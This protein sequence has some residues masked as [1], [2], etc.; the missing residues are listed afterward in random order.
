MGASDSKLS[1]KKSIFR[2]SDEARIPAHDP[3][4]TAFWELPETQ[5]DVS[6]LFSH[7]DIRRTR[8]KAFSNLESLLLA[9]TSRL[10]DLRDHPSFPDPEAAPEKHALNCIRTLT[11][12]LPFLYEIEHLDKWEKGF[13]W[14]P[15]SRLAHSG[16]ASQTEVLFDSKQGQDSPR[17]QAVDGKR[18]QRPLGEELIDTLV[19]M[20]FF[21]GFTVPPPATGQNKVTYAIWQSGV[22]CHTTLPT[23]KEFERNRCDVLKLIIVMVSKSMYMPSNI[24]PVKGVKALTHMVTCPDK[25]IV[26]SVLCSLLNTTMK[27]NPASWRVPYDHVVFKDS[28]QVLVNYCLQLLMVLV[29]Y[30]VPDGK[31]GPLGKNYFRHFLGRLHRPQ[32]FQFLVD[33]MTR[34]LNQPVQANASYLPGSQK[35]ISWAPEVIML[36]WETL[37]CNKSFRAFVVEADRAH[38]FLILIL[39][40]ALENRE[41]PS[42]HGLVRMCVFVLQTLSAER[43]FGRGLNQRFESQGTLPAS[44]RLEGFRGSYADYLI[45]SIYKLMTASQGKLHAIYPALLAILNNVA[46]YLENLNAASSSKLMQL[47]SSTSSPSFLL[48]NETNHKVLSSLLEAINAIIEHQYSGNTTFVLALLRSR[49]K[50]EALR[51]FTLECGETDIERHHRQKKEAVHGS[52]SASPTPAGSSDGIRNPTGTHARLSALQDVPEEN[53]AFAIGDDEDSE[54]DQASQTPARASPLTQEARSASVSSSIDETVPPQVR[55]MSE[56]ARGKMPAG[57]PSFSRQNSTTSLGRAMTGMSG[58]DGGFEPT[59]EWVES[60][61][62]ELPLHTILTLIQELG[63][64][65]PSNGL[66]RTSAFSTDH[67]AIRNAS[68]RG[69]EPSPIRVHLFEWS[70]LSLGWYESLLWGFIFASEISISKGAVGTWNGTAIKLFRVQEIASAGPSLMA[71]RGAVD[72]VGSN[73]VQRIGNLNFRAAAGSGAR[74]EATHDS[75]GG[76]SGSGPPNREAAV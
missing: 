26:L 9:V 54:D 18:H 52:T 60:W 53:N 12:L 28:R 35:S 2:L 30:P 67:E 3:F 49:K 8:D 42:Q 1:F 21:A 17:D 6:T 5:E 63:P 29:L 73:L 57:A 74:D 7:S 70:P 16:Q 43:R 22:G 51:L 56:K 45:I 36:F 41:D 69:I 34:V 66:S 48:A 39:F 55:G 19:D 46:A 62:P 58:H 59:T 37:Q 71:P 10:F 68:V 76:H 65:L 50:V 15:R 25:Q 31:D 13:F 47:F 33:G 72:A 24:L 64:Q 23:S 4:W 11:R 20:L 32:D 44:I 40:Y 27:Y 61:V 75:G 14:T 38:D